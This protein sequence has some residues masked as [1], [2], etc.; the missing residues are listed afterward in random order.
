MNSTG[1]KSG[2][3]KSG[4]PS[5]A[6]A[7]FRWFLEETK[8]L[9]QLLSL[10]MRGISMVQATPRLVAVIAEIE[11]KQDNPKHKAEMKT[12][13]E[14][15]DLAKNEVKED[16][17]LLRAN[18]LVAIWSLLES[19]IRTFV[20]AWI[21]NNPKA[22]TMPSISKIKVRLG[23]YHCIPD[24]DKSLYI[25]ELLETEFGANLR[26]GVNRFE[27]ML[28]LFGL[29]GEVSEETKKGIF[30]LGQIRNALV[31][32]AGHADRTLIDSCPWLPFKPGEKIKISRDIYSR[33][34]NAAGDYTLQLIIRVAEKFGKDMSKF[35]TRRKRSHTKKEKTG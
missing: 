3:N 32:R 10:A 20:A 22:M 4:V 5:W 18:N 31:H 26:N 25:A 29:S 1:N 14:M 13:Q 34:L 7:P 21:A 35:K 28:V 24:E 16:F 6:T 19:V 2:I 23:E 27:A 17:P 9:D 15:A 30:E 11:E 8:R 12:T 33:C